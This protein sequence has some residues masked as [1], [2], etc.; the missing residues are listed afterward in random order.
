MALIDVDS[1]ISI[2]ENPTLRIVSD[3]PLATPLTLD[4]TDSKDAHFSATWNG[5]DPEHREPAA[6]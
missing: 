3:Q 1:G 4:A 5:A 6:P 2:S